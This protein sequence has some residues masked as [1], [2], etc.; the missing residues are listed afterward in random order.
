MSSYSLLVDTSVWID[1]FEKGNDAIDRVMSEPNV[2]CHPFIIG[3]LSVGNLGNRH[4][5]IAALQSISQA[6]IMFEF[7][8]LK[9]IR[10]KKL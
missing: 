1:L 3:E 10:A 9:L 5:L 4:K 8:V 6:K 2:L 7:D